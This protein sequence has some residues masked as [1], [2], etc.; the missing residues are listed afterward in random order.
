MN[1]LVF[2][3]KNAYWNLYKAGEFMKVVDENV[4]PGSEA[5][6]ADVRNFFEQGLLTRNEVLKVEVQLSNVRLARLDAANAVEMAAVWLN[7]LLGL[8]L[9][10]EIEA[11]TRIDEA[12]VI[13]GVEPAAEMIRGA[14]GRRPGSSTKALGRTAGAQG[15]GSQGQS[16]R[17]G[18]HPGQVRA[19]IPRSI[20]VGKL[21]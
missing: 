5:H 11:A 2:D 3:V 8:P 9:D 1:D 4:G 6:L 15:H 14:R 20:S 13:E 19:G 10:T 21:L 16:G 17:S 18:R 7:S 12:E